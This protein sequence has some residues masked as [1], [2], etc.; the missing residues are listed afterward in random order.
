MNNSSIKNIIICGNGLA[1]A[2][3][4]LALAKALPK[5]TNG[6]INTLTPENYEKFIKKLLETIKSEWT[7]CPLYSFVEEEE[8]V[9]KIY[10]EVA[11]NAVQIVLESTTY[12]K[13]DAYINLE[14]SK[15]LYQNES[16]K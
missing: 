16:K 6:N 5:T 3:S 11:Q 8:K 13:S 10:E 7:P 1:G 15:L 2:L 4:A 14:L 9:E 12:D